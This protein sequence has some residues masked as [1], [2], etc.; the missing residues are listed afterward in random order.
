MRTSGAPKIEIIKQ[1]ADFL[2]ASRARKVAM[3]GLVLQMRERSSEGGN[4]ETAS[5]PASARV[6]YTASKKVGNAVRRNRARRRL[7]AAVNDVLCGQAKP[8]RDYVLIARGETGTRPYD[9]LCRDVATALE[10]IETVRPNAGRPRTKRPS[11]R[12][13]A[14]KASS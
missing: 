2:R 9:A 6:G 14:L 13:R 8:G 3:P 10:R 5:D 11:K 1:R 12:D 7:R 4:S